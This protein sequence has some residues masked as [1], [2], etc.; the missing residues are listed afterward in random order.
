MGGGDGDLARIAEPIFDEMRHE[1]GAFAPASDTTPSCTRP[2][3]RP[4][5]G[6][7]LR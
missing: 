3:G 5:R 1:V 2:R 7:E 4:V 6:L